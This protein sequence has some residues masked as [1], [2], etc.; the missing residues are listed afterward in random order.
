MELIIP[1]HGIALAKSL[2]N[3]FNVVSE[4]MDMPIE[5]LIAIV[6]PFRNP[7][8]TFRQMSLGLDDTFVTLGKPSLKVAYKVK[9]LTQSLNVAVMNWGDSQEFSGLLT[10]TGTNED[11][12]TFINSSE[13]FEKLSDFHNYCHGRRNRW[14]L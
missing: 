12:I 4:L 10:W 14:D 7:D 8:Y 13:V 3:S 11:D 9:L 2:N 5:V 6:F 1:L